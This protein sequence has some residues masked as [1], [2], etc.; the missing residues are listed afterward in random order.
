MSTLLPLVWF[1]LHVPALEL[2]HH[3][4]HVDSP[5]V[6]QV[7][8]AET[9]ASA[10]GIETIDTR[11]RD[12]TFT[13]VRGGEALEVTA[14][15]QHEAV[16]ALTIAPAAHPGAEL[17]GLSW[18]ASELAEATAV[19]RLVVDDDGAVAI[20][21]HEGRTYLAIPGRGSGGYRR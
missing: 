2:P 7:R 18:L 14:R 16:V 11:G 5:R 8:L 10:D 19:T 1:A 3:V 6:A 15:T 9:L 17:H 12:V 13:I 4:E 21:T 20:R